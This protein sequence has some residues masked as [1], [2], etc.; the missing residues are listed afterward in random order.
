ME[1][2]ARIGQSLLKKYRSRG[3]R[4]SNLW[5][6]FSVNTARDWIIDSDVRLIYWLLYLESH[7]DVQSFNLEPEIAHSSRGTPR[8]RIDAEVVY[9]LVKSV[10]DNLERFKRLHPAFAELKAEDMIKVGL[11]A[12]LHEGAARY[13]RERGWL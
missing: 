7:P 8:A 10:S 5:L 4:N 13:Y 11:S 6:V 1:L 12:P 2:A 3:H 9:Q